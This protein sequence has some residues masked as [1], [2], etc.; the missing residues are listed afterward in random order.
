MRGAAHG[1]DIG[2]LLAMGQRL[3]VAPERGYAIL[4]PEGG[5]RVLA[6]FDEDAASALLRAVLARAE[7]RVMVE[8]LTA[9]QQWAIAVC[10]EAGLELQGRNGRRV[11]GRRRRSVRAVSAERGVPVTHLALRF[12]TYEP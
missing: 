5:L 9:K 12:V 8:W 11:R 2:A 10:V 7:G 4:N 1:V 3:L 6:A